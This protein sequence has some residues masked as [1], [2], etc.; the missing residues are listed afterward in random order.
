[1]TFEQVSKDASQHYTLRSDLARLCLPAASRDANRKLAWTNSVCL[2]FVIIGVV[3][4]KAPELITNAVEDTSEI[5]PVVFTPPEEEPKV[6]PAPRPDE[7]EPAQDTSIETPQIATVVAADPAAA[8]FAVPVEGPVVF[9]PARF[10]SAPP[11][12]PPKATSNPKPTLFVKSG[13]SGGAYPDPTYPSLALRRRNEG[14]VLLYVIVDP[15]GSPTSVEVRDTS[16]YTLLDTHSVDWVRNKWRWPA[17]ET[18][19]YF[20]PIEYQIR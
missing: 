3:G 19:H 17:G 1:M 6:E 9:A 14:K 10:A 12:N 11:P 2:L 5:V 15:S 4:L 18:R 8:A 7:P 16:G 13:K 20:V